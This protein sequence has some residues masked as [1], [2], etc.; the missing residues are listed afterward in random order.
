MNFTTIPRHS[1]IHESSEEP[2]DIPRKSPNH[3]GNYT[4]TSFQEVATTSPSSDTMK[5]RMRHEKR[6]SSQQLSPLLKS[7]TFSRRSIWPHAPWWRSQT[8]P[9]TI[10]VQ[11]SRFAIGNSEGA[12]EGLYRC[13]WDP[14]KCSRN[15]VPKI[16]T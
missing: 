11:L 1:H 10:G 8:I 5:T 13:G 3:T 15:R 9:A 14:G 4:Q 6:S 2:S 16:S 7:S 12:A